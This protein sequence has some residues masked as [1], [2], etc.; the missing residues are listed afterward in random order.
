NVAEDLNGV[1]AGRSVDRQRIAVNAGSA[2]E[3]ANSLGRIEEAE[4]VT[5]YET[6]VSR[7]YDA[8]P[9][10]LEKSEAMSIGSLSVPV[11][12]GAKMGGAFIAFDWVGDSQWAPS[13]IPK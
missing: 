11:D 2:A 8:S 13:A 3:I 9:S 4:R 6:V 7:S 12:A 1:A 10:G 5:H